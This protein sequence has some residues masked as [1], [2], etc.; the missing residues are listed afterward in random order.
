MASQGNDERGRMGTHLQALL[1]GFD[2]RDIASDTTA[3]DDEVFLLSFGGVRAS[4]TW[5]RDGREG[6]LGES[7]A[8]RSPRY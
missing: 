1:A 4:P 7:R 2:G 3:D 8:D 5:E 6:G